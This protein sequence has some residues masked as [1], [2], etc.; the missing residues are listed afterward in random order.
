MIFINTL[1]MIFYFVLSGAIAALLIKIWL[2]EKDLQKVVLISVVLIPFIL[3]VL[4]IK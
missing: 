1:I 3:R 4:G 2:K